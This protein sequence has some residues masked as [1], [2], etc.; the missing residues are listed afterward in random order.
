MV[1]GRNGQENPYTVTLNALWR[2]ESLRT[3]YL[4]SIISNI[5]WHIF[6]NKEALTQ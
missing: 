1:F 2:K 5:R 6:T 3:N 4:P